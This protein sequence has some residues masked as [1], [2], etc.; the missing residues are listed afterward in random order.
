MK[1]Y[2]VVMRGNIF[3]FT[4]KTNSYGFAKWLVDLKLWS[5]AKIHDAKASDVNPPWSKCIYIND[6]RGSK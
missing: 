4:F 2:F 5:Y 3:G 6:R 1:R